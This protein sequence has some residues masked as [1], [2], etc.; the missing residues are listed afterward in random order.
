VDYDFEWDS[1][2]ALINQRKHRVTFELA[3]TVFRDPRALTIFDNEHNDT[4]DRW[5][6]MGLASSGGL[7]VVHHTFK[8][9][10]ATRSVIRIFSSRK[11]SKNEMQQYGE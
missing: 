1:K 9:V 3:A 10:D 6:T 5:I 11:A 4:E 2:K 7:L 8:A